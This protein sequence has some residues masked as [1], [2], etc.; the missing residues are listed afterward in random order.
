MKL[1][2]CAS[3]RRS[4]SGFHY[5]SLALLSSSSIQRKLL[6]PRIS[7]IG[8][9]VFFSEEPPSP[10]Y[11]FNIVHRGKA[12]FPMENPWRTQATELSTAVPVILRGVR[13]TKGGLTRMTVP[14]EWPINDMALFKVIFWCSHIF[15]YF[16]NGKPTIWGIYREY[17][18][19]VFWSPEANQRWYGMWYVASPKIGYGYVGTLKWINENQWYVIWYLAMIWNDMVWYGTTWYDMV[20]IWY[21]MVWYGMNMVW[22]GMIWYDR[23]LVALKLDD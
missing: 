12:V 17:M 15:P 9:K 5:T 3:F 7:S 14:G 1:L 20:W 18:L 8:L 2:R 21:D 19:Y 22:Y 11:F 4:S 23:P 10:S 6:N 16:P 13:G